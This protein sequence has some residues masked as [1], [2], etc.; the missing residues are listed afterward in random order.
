VLLKFLVYILF[1]ILLF[2]SC[3]E[4]KDE[5]AELRMRNVYDE[6]TAI[7]HVLGDEVKNQLG[8][9]EQIRATLAAT[10]GTPKEIE[11]IKT[12]SDFA[13]ICH[14]RK[15]EIINN[16]VNYSSELIRES[17]DPKFGES[18]NYPKTNFHYYVQPDRYERYQENFLLPLNLLNNLHQLDIASAYFASNESKLPTAIIDSMYSYRSALCQYFFIENGLDNSQIEEFNQ[19]ELKNDGSNSLAKL[20]DDLAKL[21]ASSSMLSEDSTTIQNIY[22]KLSLP[23]KIKSNDTEIEWQEY[24]FRDA[25]ILDAIIILEGLKT[26][27]HFAEVE[28]NK[29]L[30]EKVK[31]E[32]YEFNK[33]EIIATAK[34]GVIKNGEL[35]ELKLNYMAYDSTK[36][37]Q[38]K[39]WLD[40]SSETSDSII[41]KVSA[42][43]PIIIPTLK[44]GTHSITGYIKSDNS[45]DHWRHWNYTYFIFE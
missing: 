22:Q 27:L 36:E 15:V 38:V 13:S 17:D 11:D 28:L 25:N 8:K 1:S 7:N 40:D 20:S 16:F 14:S 45:R 41:S 29:N 32:T 4:G 12:N 44:T 23:R 35:L 24:Y 5:I 9:L 37:Y 34:K 19:L 3:E 2:A 39:Y 18:E 10:G 26:D 30:L 42:V 6:L 33:L 31:P 43:N 21:L